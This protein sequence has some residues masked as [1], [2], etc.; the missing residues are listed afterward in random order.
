MTTIL[1]T[2]PS[3]RPHSTS[4]GE[5]NTTFRPSS[6]SKSRLIVAFVGLSATLLLAADAAAAA[7]FQAPP[8]PQQWLE[9]Q[10]IRF[11]FADLQTADRARDVARRIRTAARYVC[12]GDDPIIRTSSGFDLCVSASVRQAISGL[13]APL[14]AQALGVTPPGLRG[15]QLA[16][17]GRAP[18]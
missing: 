8:K 14:L 2:T 12:E 17:S 13:D 3:H 7:S 18:D 11:R 1:R 9:S 5:I 15:G 4:V 16:S 6:H 10:T